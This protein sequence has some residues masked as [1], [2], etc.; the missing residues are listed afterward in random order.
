MAKKIYTQQEVVDKLDKHI[1]SE[2]TGNKTAFAKDI[3]CSSGYIGN[4]LS[5]RKPPSDKI[6]EVFGLKKVDGYIKG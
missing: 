4:V 5:K 6:L 2:Y 1:K 3:G